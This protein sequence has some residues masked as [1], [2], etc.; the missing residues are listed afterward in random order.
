MTSEPTTGVSLEAA[1]QIGVGVT[2]RLDAIAKQLDAMNRLNQNQP[3]LHR[4]VRA[5]SSTSTTLIL[6]LGKPDQGYYWDVEQ[7]TAGG[8]DLNVTAA[9]S[10]GLYVTG[11]LTTVSP[12]LGYAVDYAAS[13]PNVGFYGFRDIVVNAS[14][15]LYAVIFTPTASQTY[16]VNAAVSVY[17]VTAGE[18]RTV[19]VAGV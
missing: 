15:H 8:T 16:V 9:G 1:F 5:G 17:P 11:A 2:T 12:G 18:G 14:E 10:L 19:N 13:L 4:I 3:I 7:V 6:D